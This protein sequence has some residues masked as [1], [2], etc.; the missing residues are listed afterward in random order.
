MHDDLEIL[1]STYENI[2]EPE[3]VSWRGENIDL[4]GPGENG[5]PVDPSHFGYSNNEIK[6]QYKLH[7]FNVI[8]SDLISL[9]RFLPD[10]RNEYCKAKQFPIGYLPTTSIIIVFY[11]EAFSTLLRTIHSIINRTPWTLLEEIILIDDA[12]SFEHLKSKLESTI[13]EY[14]VKIRIFRQTTRRG[15]IQA[16]ILGA[17]KANGNTLTFLDA[18][19]ECT[20]NWLPPLLTSIK[21][22]RKTVTCPIIDVISDESFEYLTGSEKTYGGFNWKLNFRWY[23]IPE[24]EYSRRNYDQT[25]PVKSPAMAGGLFTIHG[26]QES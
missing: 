20:K 17:K 23:P 1:E 22:N 7:Q 12:S 3:I 11:N 18:H 24:S 15:L 19:C 25:E 9:D 21:K 16:R 26:V 13:K 6:E 14:P 4:L 8:A 5:K 10:V 2:A